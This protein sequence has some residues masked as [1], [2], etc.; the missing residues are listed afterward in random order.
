MSDDIKEEQWLANILTAAQGGSDYYEL[1][2]IIRKEF[3]YYDIIQA[4]KNGGGGGGG[5]S[6]YSQLTNKPKINNV[7]LAGN[8]N[9]DDIGAAS[10]SDMADEQAKT[11]GMT[12]GGSNY[13]TV[14]GKR[15]Y[16]DSNP[17]TGARIGDLWIGG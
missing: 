15:V 1:D 3:Y 9:L 6:D 10:A 13:I 14:G 12:E 17:P 11:T 2:P 4:L 16:V 8:K 7:E 5:T